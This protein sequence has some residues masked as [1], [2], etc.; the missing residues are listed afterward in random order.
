MSRVQA[1][2]HNKTRRL[3]KRW[4]LNLSRAQTSFS[5]CVVV[6]RKGGAISE[7]VWSMISGNRGY[8]PDGLANQISRSHP[9]KSS[10]LQP[11][12]RESNGTGPP[13][14]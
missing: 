2:Y 13:K 4:T 6:V 1:Q 9:Y 10:G 14:D 5:L 8:S 12:V 3:G 11:P 7:L